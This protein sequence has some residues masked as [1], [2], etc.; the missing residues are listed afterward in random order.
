[1]NLIYHL[2]RKGRA[3]GLSQESVETVIVTVTA[4]S[5]LEDQDLAQEINAASNNIDQRDL[6]RGM[7]ATAVGETPEAVAEIVTE[8]EVEMVVATEMKEIA[9]ERRTAMEIIKD[10]HPLREGP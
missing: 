9:R 7:E 1:M 5:V 10:C 8:A 3:L 4:K 6:V 2:L